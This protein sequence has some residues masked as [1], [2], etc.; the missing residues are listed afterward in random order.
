MKHINGVS[1]LNTQF[2][3]FHNVTLKTNKL[4][5]SIQFKN[6]QNRC[7]FSYTQTTPKID[8]SVQFQYSNKHL[9]TSRSNSYPL[10]NNLQQFN[11]RIQQR[12]YTT[13]ASESQRDFDNDSSAAETEVGTDIKELKKNLRLTMKAL[14]PDRFALHEEARKTNQEAFQVLQAILSDYEDA[15]QLNQP[16]R[17][18]ERTEMYP[19]SFFYNENDEIH[20]HS[21]MLKSPSYGNPYSSAST[22]HDHLTEIFRVLG[23]PTESYD[24]ESVLLY[25][26]GKKEEAGVGFLVGFLQWASQKA[27]PIMEESRRQ[28]TE[29]MEQTSSNFEVHR[30]TAVAVSSLR[31]SRLN[32]SPEISSARQQTHILGDLQRALTNCGGWT[33]DASWAVVLDSTRTPKYVKRFRK[34]LSRLSVTIDKGHCRVNPE[35][36]EVIFGTRDLPAFKWL[37]WAATADLSAAHQIQRRHEECLQ[38]ERDIVEKLNIEA[39][40]SQDQAAL[41]DPLFHQWL[42]SLAHSPHLRRLRLSHPERLT[43]VVRHGP[44]KQLSNQIFFDEVYGFVTVSTQVT[45]EQVISFLEQHGERACQIR[46]HYEQAA[47]LL[48]ESLTDGRRALRLRDLAAENVDDLPGKDETRP[49]IPVSKVQKACRI[50]KSN[51]DLLLGYAQGLRLVITGGR[52]RVLDSGAIAISYKVLEGLEKERE[53]EKE[54]D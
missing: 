17:Q 39:I 6:N 35:T 22:L 4:S 1:T 38:F 23:L 32:F 24:E 48:Q 44:A 13:T 3:S 25:L 8:P 42:Q 7:F 33:W 37:D 34:N 19:V 28:M 21:I 30:S 5:N 2:N 20:Q 31:V 45:P 10:N 9:N 40:I 15:I 52:S 50:L 16:Q 43:V 49:T 18:G 41:R 12:F 54:N 36:G 47:D 46:N 14:H 11:Y 53:R 51:V 27:Q 26:G 29:N